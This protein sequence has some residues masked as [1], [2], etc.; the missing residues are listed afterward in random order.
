[1]SSLVLPRFPRGF[2]LSEGPVEP[3]PDF[4]PGPLLKHFYVHPWANVQFAGDQALFVIVMGH[5][6]PIRS[7]QSQDVAAHL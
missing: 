3:P 2:L 1:M 7:G 4:I 5:C 6:V